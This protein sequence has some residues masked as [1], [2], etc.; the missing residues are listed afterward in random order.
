LSELRRVG[1]LSAPE[2]RVTVVF[3]HGLGGDCVRTWQCDEE[4][5]S[6][7]P[8]WLAEDI[9]GSAVYT[10]GYEASPSAWFGTAM[11]LL[12]R[13]TNALALLTAEDISA[14]PIVFVCHS[15]GGLVVKQM[16]R[17]AEDYGE[18]QWKQLREQT[19]A[20]IFLAT[21]HLGA[22]LAGYVGALSRIL[23]VT[24]A[25]RDMES[26]AAPL[27]DLNIW[28]TNN[29]KKMGIETRAFFETR[30]TA[31]VRVVDERSAYLSLPGVVPIP[32]DADH[33]TICKPRSRSDLVY[34]TI[35]RLVGEVG[36]TLCPE[37]CDLLSDQTERCRASNVPFRT[38]HFFAAL[39]KTK[40][41]L[42]CICL[43]RV[44]T[45]AATNFKAELDAFVARQK[46]LESGIGFS[47]IL[48]YQHPII[49]AARII[50]STEKN[51]T[52]NERHLFISLLEA[53]GTTIAR[54]KQLYGPESF[55]QL[56]KI[57]RSASDRT[58]TPWVLP[59]K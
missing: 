48:L 14:R 23:R 11:P 39:F 53:D 16:L 17:N 6:F 19:R 52:I 40:K 18:P 24:T 35:N 1:E 20:V 10:L 34:K 43:N 47:E 12:D 3:V 55:G 57:V 38:P 22:D 46:E 27:R 37:I 44:N 25:V 56:S 4:A 26:N 32:V 30:G 7:W 13:A 49:A 2:G 51:N 9:P 21:P 8:A 28:Y 42:A 58:L 59:L 50:A 29:V 54:L 5:E 45:E 15:L 33:L 36:I 41:D 31:G